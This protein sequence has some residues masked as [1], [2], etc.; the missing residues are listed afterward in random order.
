MKKTY[1]DCKRPLLFALMDSVWDQVCYQ[2]KPAL[3]DKV[4]NDIWELVGMQ[5]D[6]SVWSHVWERETERM[7]DTHL[8]VEVMYGIDY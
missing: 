1:N 2:T 7:L 4:C 6:E 3:W 8:D 5:V